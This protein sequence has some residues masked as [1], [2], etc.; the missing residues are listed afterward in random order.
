LQIRFCPTQRRRAFLPINLVKSILERGGTERYSIRRFESSDVGKTVELLNLVFKPAIPFT[1]EW[2]NWKYKSNPAGGQVDNG[3]VWI[4]EDGQELVGYYAVMPEKFKIDGKTVTC[5]QSVDTA[6]H[7]K[8][9][10]LGMFSRLAQNVYSDVKNRYHFAFGFPSRMACNGFLK[11]GWKGFPVDDYI[12]FVRYDRLS[13]SLSDNPVYGWLGKA[14]LKTLKV[15]TP[16]FSKLHPR[17]SGKSL[18]IDEIDA[19]P[20]EVDALWQVAR[21]ENQI[22]LERDFDFLSWRFSRL[23]G[24]YHIYIGRSSENGSIKGYAVLKKTKILDI[25]DVLEIVDLW[26]LPNEDNFVSNIIELAIKKSKEENLSLVHCRVPS[27]HRHSK[28]LR[29]LG[30]IKINR[31][32]KLLRM[33]QPRAIYYDFGDQRPIPDL[34][35]WFYTMADTDNA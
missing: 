12:R 25:N 34:K 13:D 19:F 28:I 7:P 31:Y 10:R 8:Y 11:M 15:T 9:R 22:V 2:W 16:S 21:L 20:R 35:R 26:A 17:K 14:F 5:A 27:W 32:L 6:V 23:F 24:D 30:F 18:E 33:N 3:D 1:S 4:A 29:N